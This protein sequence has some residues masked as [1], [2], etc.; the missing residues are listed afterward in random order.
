M[1]TII[2]NSA[3]GSAKLPEVHTFET[4]EMLVNA[5]QRD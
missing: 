2:K 3:V 1:C 4:C 5:K